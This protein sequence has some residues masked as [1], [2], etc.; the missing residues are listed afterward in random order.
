MKAKLFLNA[1]LALTLLPQMWTFLLSLNH[2]A[3]VKQ[4]ISDSD[5]S[6]LVIWYFLLSY[7]YVGIETRN[8]CFICSKILVNTPFVDCSP[9][10]TPSVCTCILND[11]YEKMFVLWASIVFVPLIDIFKY[12][13]GFSENVICAAGNKVTNL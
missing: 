10:L 9:L 5:M 3:P 6:L 8:V 1:V 12:E 4:S 2:F 7:I 11:Y 13:Y